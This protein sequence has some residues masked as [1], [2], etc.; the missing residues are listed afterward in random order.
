MIRTKWCI[1]LQNGSLLEIN[2]RFEWLTKSIALKHAR[3]ARKEGM[4]CHVT[5][6][7]CIT[8]NYR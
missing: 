5:G 3:Q 4:E 8:A 7:N 6:S 2:G 1:T